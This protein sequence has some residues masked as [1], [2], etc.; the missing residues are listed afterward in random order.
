[1]SALAPAVRD[2]RATALLA[3]YDGTRSLPTFTGTDPS[4][5]LAEAYQVA[6]EIRAGESPAAS[7]ARLQDS[8]TNRGIWHATAFRDIGGRL[9]HDTAR[10]A[11][12]QQVRGA[13]RR[14][15]ARPEVM[16]G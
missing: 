8:F 12:A 1:M 2:E 5:Q 10:V 9:G 15:P 6:D 13:L 14:A 7:G 16:F 4:F 11:A 3:A